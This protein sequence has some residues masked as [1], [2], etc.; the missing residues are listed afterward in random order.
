MKKKKLF[1]LLLNQ[2]REQVLILHNIIM[3]MV[4]GLEDASDEGPP[5]PAMPGLDPVK[6]ETNVEPVGEYLLSYR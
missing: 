5:A 6:A 4:A 1:R 2:Q 3:K